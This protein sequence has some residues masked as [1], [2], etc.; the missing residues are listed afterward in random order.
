[1][2]AERKVGHPE[3]IAEPMPLKVSS[4]NGMGTSLKDARVRGKKK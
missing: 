1:L 3:A 4:V 2:L